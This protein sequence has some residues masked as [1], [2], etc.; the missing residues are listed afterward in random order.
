MIKILNYGLLFCFCLLQAAC[1]NN[2][3]DDV[4]D[5]SKVNSTLKLPPV[6]KKNRT[7][8]RLANYYIT[9]QKPT[10]A[11]NRATRLAQWDVVIIHHEY[12]NITISE[13]KTVNPNIKVLLWI[14]FGQEGDPNAPIAATVPK[15]ITDDN[16]D[17]IIDN[18]FIKNPDGDY[19]TIMFDEHMMNPIKHDKDGN[20]YAWPE[21]LYK[22]ITETYFTGINEELE[23]DGLFFD[24]MNENAPRWGST[25]GKV[26]IDEDGD[27]DH[28][29]DLHWQEGAVYLLNKFRNNFP[30]KIFTLNNGF[31]LS[32]ECNYYN[33]INGCYHE[34]ALGDQWGNPLWYDEWNAPTTI[35]G[36]YITAMD[37]TIANETYNMVGVD[38]RH[39][40]FKEY[41]AARDKANL[42]ND[43]FR[44]MRLGLCTTLL[45]DGYFGFDGG[46]CLHGQLWWFDE[47]DVDLGEPLEEYK[48]PNNIT[49]KTNVYGEGTFS[50][51]FENGIV[52]VNVGFSAKI[53]RF[54]SSHTDATTKKSGK[55][56][57]L[58]SNDGR[59]FIKD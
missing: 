53:I 17:G 14:P 54:S 31:A 18:W 11:D 45:D 39:G 51:K 55:N 52:I 6:T 24:C 38:I 8:P 21:H 20:P 42:N 4:I 43:D 3:D 32:S 9:T 44:R 7:Y 35:W 22:Y 1:L 26:D 27:D 12:E 2:N 13:L 50:R 23:Y 5:L 10:I 46:D 47:Y 25:T 48:R 16:N 28:D 37:N 29:D 49:Y 56:F 19:I 40:D 59:I 57:S 15:E 34:N 30:D 33:Y 36:S 58:P 41:E